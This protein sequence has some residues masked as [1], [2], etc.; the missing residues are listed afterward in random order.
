MHEL[1][2]R[3]RLCVA[4]GKDVLVIVQYVSINRVVH[5]VLSPLPS[6]ICDAAY[7]VE[8]PYVR[9]AG[10]PITCLLCIVRIARSPMLRALCGEL[11]VHWRP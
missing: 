7:D 10:P 3:C 5:R 4:G 11:E 9:A 8:L 2:D 1:P 6:L